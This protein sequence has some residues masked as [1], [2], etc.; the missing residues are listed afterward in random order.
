MPE[1][2]RLPLPFGAGMDRT[3][4][5]Y[6]VAPGTFRE[7]LN[8]IVKEGKV[9]VRK[10]LTEQITIT[11]DGSG[12][13]AT[14]LVA[15]GVFRA[16]SRGVVLAHELGGGTDNVEVWVT[17]VTGF[18]P[19]FVDTVT[20][21][22][23]PTGYIPRFFL[24]ES[25]SR[26][27]TGHDEADITQRRPTRMI[28]FTAPNTFTPTTLQAD[29]DGAGDDDVF[30]RGVERHLNYLFGWGFGSASEPDRSEVVRVSLPGDPTQWDKQHYFLAGVRGEP[31]LRGISANNRFIVF[32]DSETYAITGYDRPSFGITI[33]DPVYG[34]AGARLAAVVAGETFF[35][36]REG[37]RVLPMDGPSIDLGLPLDLGG[38][39]PADLTE[40]G[41][42]ADGWTHYI[43]EERLMLF[44]FPNRATGKTPTYCLS[45]RDPAT[46]RWSYLEF[47]RC[48]WSVGTMYAVPGGAPTGYPLLG[49]VSAASETITVPFTD[50]DAIG[51]EIVEVW[52]SNDTDDPGVFTFIREF[53]VGSSH[54][55]VLTSLDGVLPDKDW[56]VALRYRRGSY[57]GADYANP[58]TAGWSATGLGHSVASVTTT[59]SP[60][61]P[62]DVQWVQCVVQSYGGKR[63]LVVGFSWV[64]GIATGTTH[65]YQHVTNT[66]GHATLLGSYPVTGLGNTD[67]SPFDDTDPDNPIGLG[68]WLIVPGADDRYIWA[69]HEDVDGNLS[70]FVPLVGQ[71]LVVRNGCVA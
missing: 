66:P 62:S 47:E 34:I 24:A 7:L 10:G 27:F 29:L 5:E 37:P 18:G 1:R 6:A 60:A 35:W 4:G 48:L 43:P 55:E 36:S 22:S 8:L 61:V 23:T 57:F 58:V 71:P 63:Y 15:V 69:R 70:E 16:A 3:T 59:P 41:Q 31:V 25:Y 68:F 26:L 50:V 17:S 46:V 45:L 12:Q 42:V 33:V 54:E 14:D 40:S 28:Q 39:S 52:L 51:D 19:V 44:G 49:S 56:K 2:T 9:Q 11:M 53:P 20:A 65:L 67:H 38:P 13:P 30:F 64:D 21:P 32:K